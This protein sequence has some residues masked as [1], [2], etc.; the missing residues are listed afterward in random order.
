[1]N[2][3]RIYDASSIVIDEHG[4]VQL[5]A[6]FHGPVRHADGQL[7]YTV[8]L[9]DGNHRA[10]GVIVV[11]PELGNQIYGLAM[12]KKFHCSTQ[13]DGSENALTIV[14]V[15]IGDTEVTICSPLPY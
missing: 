9:S 10:T 11:A 5:S 12:I 6:D 4:N 8:S 3:I 7:E 15:F 14:G 1:M 2:G 13:T